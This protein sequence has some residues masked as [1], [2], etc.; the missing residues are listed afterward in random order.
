MNHHCTQEVGVNYRLE[1]AQRPQRNRRLNITQHYIPIIYTRDF[2]MKDSLEWQYLSYCK[3]RVHLASRNQSVTVDYSS[4][5][6]LTM[7]PF[8]KRALRRLKKRHL[9]DCAL[10]EDLEVV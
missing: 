10:F 1:I 5:P 9:H 8:M 4:L 7:L 6:S 2:W 3:L